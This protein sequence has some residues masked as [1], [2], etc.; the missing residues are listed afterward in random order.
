M[1]YDQWKMRSDR[2]D[3]EPRYCKPAYDDEHWRELIETI[4]GRIGA[5]RFLDLVREVLKDEP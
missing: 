5:E 2:D 1:T 3:A 4:V